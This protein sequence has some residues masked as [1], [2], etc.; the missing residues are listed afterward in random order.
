MRKQAQDIKRRY[1]ER[2]EPDYLTDEQKL[3]NIE[4]YLQIEKDLGIKRGRPMSHEQANEMRGNPHYGESKAYSVNCQ[5]Y[6]RHTNCACEAS[7]FRHFPTRQARRSASYRK[8][9]TPH[10]RTSRE[11]TS[12]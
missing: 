9:R 11:K 10:G 4:A 7:M 3:A 5:T 2:F 8:Q 1:W 12:R 6:G